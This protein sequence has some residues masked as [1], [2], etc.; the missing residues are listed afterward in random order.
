MGSAR[1]WPSAASNPNPIAGVSSFKRTVLG[2]ASA[3]SASACL[4]ELE[5]VGCSPAPAA[6][7]AAGAAP[8]EAKLLTGPPASGEGTPPSRVEAHVPA[9]VGAAPPPKPDEGS[10]PEC[11]A[12][13]CRLFE[14][15]EQAFSFVLASK[16]LVLA[17][18]EAHALQGTEAIASTTARFT[19]QLLP[20]AAPTSSDIIIELMQP[21]PRCLQTTE[22]VRKEQKEVT[23][24]QAST[25][26]NE[27]VTLGTRAKEAGVTPHILYPSCPEYD[28]IA[29]A[30]ENSIFVMLETIGV[31]TERKARAILDRN[32]KA[33]AERMLLLYG[34]AVHNDISPRAG[35]ETWSYGPSLNAYTNGRYVELD[36]I[37]REYI[38]DTEV[39]QSQPWYAHFDRSTH[40]RQAV[41]FQ[42]SPRSFVLI[43]PAST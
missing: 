33:G 14:S 28:R 19:N 23:K 38:K 16:P 40:T 26:Q 25:N 21:D 11:T 41:L 35:R 10:G 7:S 4:L 37:V 43:F 1:R 12:L 36:L 30:G 18:G 24:S 15:P 13:E 32:H 8:A 6:N 31:L 27:F 17:V 2:L 42:P 29:K 3:V 22:Q 9:D 20:L 39:W 34:G 5:V